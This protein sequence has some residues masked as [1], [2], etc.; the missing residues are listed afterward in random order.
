M[1]NYRQPQY[2][3]FAQTFFPFAEEFGDNETMFFRLKY[4]INKGSF[5]SRLSGNPFY[6]NR[7]FAG[8]D[9]LGGLPVDK[10]KYRLIWESIESQDFYD[11]ITETYGYENGKTYSTYSVQSV[12][13]AGR[14]TEID[15]SWNVVNF[16]ESDIGGYIASGVDLYPGDVVCFQRPAARRE[17]GTAYRQVFYAISDPYTIEKPNFVS[18]VQFTIPSNDKTCSLSEILESND[19]LNNWAV[20]QSAYVQVQ[21]KAI[22]LTS[23]AIGVLCTT[24]TK[25]ILNH[26]NVIPRSYWADEY[27]NEVDTTKDAHKENDYNGKMVV[28]DSQTER[29][30]ETGLWRQDVKFTDWRTV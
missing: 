13:C 10:S 27:G 25:F 14:Y 2:V 6:A 24:Q 26:P 18:N 11:E 22:E 28:E 19:W 5:K 15:S 3:G 30:T 4:R 21:K 16:T 20:G 1:Y 9:V 29:D 8:R 23:R 12:S 17:F 7:T